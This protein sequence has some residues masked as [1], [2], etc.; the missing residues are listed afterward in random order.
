MDYEGN[1]YGENPV[2]DMAVDYDYHIITGE[3]PSVIVAKEH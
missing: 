1:E 2:D 3:F